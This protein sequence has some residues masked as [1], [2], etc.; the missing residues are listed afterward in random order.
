V[1]GGK[2]I[3]T[4]TATVSTTSMSVLI[5]GEAELISYSPAA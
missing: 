5:L 2:R 1:K 3:T 4:K